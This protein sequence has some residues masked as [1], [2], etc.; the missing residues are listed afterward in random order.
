[1]ASDL[2]RV[3]ASMLVFAVVAGLIVGVAGLLGATAVPSVPTDDTEPREYDVD[4]LY[5][6]RVDAEGVVDVDVEDPGV[7]LIDQ[8]HD[9]ALETGDLRKLT[10]A[11][12]A[13]GNEVRVADSTTTFDDELED[14]DALVVIDPQT[15]YASDRADAVA[16]FADGDGRL[17]LVGQ[18]TRAEVVGFEIQTRESEADGI[19]NRL[20]FS[21]GTD[22]VYDMEA[23]D[24]NH[25]NIQV[26]GT[27]VGLVEDIDEAYVYTTTYVTA[28]D[29]EPLLVTSEQAQ[30]SEDRN[31]QQYTIA[32]ATGSV[33]AIG[34]ANFLTGDRYNVGDNEELIAA[35]VT[36]L[37]DGG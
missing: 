12:I 25:R 16:E 24:G 22:Y 17:L 13:A 6:E 20:G 14:A 8:A 4:G 2:A 10:K 21:F 23:N 28:A 29:A 32:A 34:D 5:V 33:M 19:A 15:R 18:P 37:S 3:L 35:I 11:L 36:Y 27:D 9:N 26:Q 30:R 31:P 7:V 1:M